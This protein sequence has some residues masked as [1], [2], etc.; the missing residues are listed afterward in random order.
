M[1][2]KIYVQ[3]DNV[4]KELTGQELDDYLSDLAI[5][6]AEL[7]AVKAEAEAEAAAKETQRQVI[8]DR[9]GLTS[10]EARLLLG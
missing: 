3:I 5:C 10:D 4:K 2:E 7:L 8:L 9:L 6:N 1:S